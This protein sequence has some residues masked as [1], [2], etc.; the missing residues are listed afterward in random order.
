MT[1]RLKTFNGNFLTAWSNKI[2]RKIIN[3]FIKPASFLEN[4]GR[5][6]TRKVFSLKINDDLLVV[7]D[8][9]YPL[10]EIIALEFDDNFNSTC[11]KISLLSRDPKKPNS[12]STKSYLGIADLNSATTFSQTLD[13]KSISVIHYG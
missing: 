12:L 5:A 1:N 3:Y 7:N 13:S 6:Q 8:K 2:I 9:S 10:S 11:T 4:T